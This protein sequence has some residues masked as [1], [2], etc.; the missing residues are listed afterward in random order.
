MEPS[1]YTKVSKQI[2]W[3]GTPIKLPNKERAQKLLDRVELGHVDSFTEVFRYYRFAYSPVNDEEREVLE[4][5]SEAY[6]AGCKI[7]K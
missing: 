6:N 5:I 2:G 4:I 1:V 3:G 7:F